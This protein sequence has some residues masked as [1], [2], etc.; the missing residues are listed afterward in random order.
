MVRLLAERSKD[1]FVSVQV[2]LIVKLLLL[3]GFKFNRII[4][5]SLDAFDPEKRTLEISFKNGHNKQVFLELPYSLYKD[6]KTHYD[7]RTS[8]KSGNSNLFIT[9][10][11]SLITNAFISDFLNKARTSYFSGSKQDEYLKNPFTPTGLAKY[12]ITN[13][14]LQGMDQ[15]TIVH[16]TGVENDIYQDCKDQISYE[17][18]NRMINHNFRGIKTFDLL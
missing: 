11:G 16:I 8:Y 5:L 15:S 10:A 6:M 14:I 9:R 18:Y 1:T 12:A 2:K 13:M 17:D 3:Y 4:E 7:I